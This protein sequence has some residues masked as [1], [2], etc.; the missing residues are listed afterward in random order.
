MGKNRAIIVG[1]S[2][3]MGR[4]VAELLLEEG[5]LVGVAA[6][7]EEP[8]RELETRFPGQVTVQTLDVCATDCAQRLLE[9]IERMGGVDL[10]LHAS[11]I[12]KQ[13]EPLETAIELST[14]STNA[15]GFTCCVDTVFDWM[16]SH[17]GGHLAV[18]SSIA[19]TKG[20]GAAPAYSA[21]KAFQNTYIE[22]LEQL[23]GMRR[24]N[25][26]FTDI[27][28]GFVATPL[29]GD[30]PHYPLLMDCDTVARSIVS[31]LHAQR[32]VRVIDFRYRC[33]VLLWRCVP[34]WLWRRLVL[35]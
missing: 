35:R 27:R 22:A 28:P 19:G 15:W 33:L 6:R 13:N 26:R 1:A 5:W 18:I 7:R 21:T 29:L 2:S 30:A 34:R 8:L 16:A 14:V 11:G 17:G 25:I 24:L 10:Y 32:H 23:A 9:L 20:L 3:G 31:T 4:R 12:G